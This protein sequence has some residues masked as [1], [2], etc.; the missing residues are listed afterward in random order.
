MDA[1]V[2]AERYYQTESLLGLRRAHRHRDHLAAVLI[3][4]PGRVRHGEGVERVQQQRHALTLERLRLLVE[5]DRV[6]AWN[7]LDEADDLH[8]DETIRPCSACST[9][10]T[11]TCRRSTLCSPTPR[12]WESAAGCS[13]ATTGRRALGRSRRSA[14]CASS[15]TRRGSAATASAGSASRRSTGRR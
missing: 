14:G 13:A 10:S 7:L 12:S 11:A 9:T 2:R 4:Q 1:A 5:L 6:G 8:G 15:K 3:P